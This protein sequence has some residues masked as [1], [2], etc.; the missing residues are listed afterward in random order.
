KADTALSREGEKM[1]SRFGSALGVLL[2][3][4]GSMGDAPAQG[5]LSLS[6]DLDS[7]I[8]RTIGRETLPVRQALSQGLS[9]EASSPTTVVLGSVLSA[10]GRVVSTYK[11]RP[12]KLGPGTTR[13][14]ADQL[15]GDEFLPGNRFTPGDVYIPGDM[16]FPIANFERFA[17]SMAR[18]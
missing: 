17:Q 10:D 7:G 12:F 16:Y 9:I 8:S 15:P 2:L 13:V 1:T 3:T 11:S 18:S 4:L 6:L 14:P 5:A